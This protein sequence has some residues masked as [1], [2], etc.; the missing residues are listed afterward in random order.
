MYIGLP[1][2]FPK[3]PWALS[4]LPDWYPWVFKDKQEAY[5]MLLYIKENYDKVVEEMAPMRDFIRE[6]Y[7]SGRIY[8]VLEDRMIELT[9]QPR[10]FMNAKSIKDLILRAT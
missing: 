1:V 3:K 7:S 5:S 10:S 4:Q 2:L 8:T 9:Q 6:N